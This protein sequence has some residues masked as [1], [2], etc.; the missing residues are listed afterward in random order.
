MAQPHAAPTGE[1]LAEEMAKISYEPF[2]P[3]ERKLVTWSLV[4]GLVLLVVLVIIGTAIFP[5]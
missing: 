5:G 4:L 3:V 1:K 2:L